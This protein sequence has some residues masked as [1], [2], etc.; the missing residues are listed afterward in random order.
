MAKEGDMSAAR[1]VI[2]SAGSASEG[3]SD[4]SGRC[5]RRVLPRA[6][7]Q[8]QASHPASGC[9]RRPSARRGRD[10]AGIVEARR[11]A[12][13]TLELEQRITALESKK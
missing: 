4:L 13:E 7:P 6:S 11:K 9:G 5:R 10:L 2:E 12:V 8:A 1:L 3:A